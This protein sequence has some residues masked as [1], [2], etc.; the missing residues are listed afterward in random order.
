VRNII[1]SH[2]SIE[3]GYITPRQGFLPLVL[4]TPQLLLNATVSTRLVHRLTDSTTRRKYHGE[5]Y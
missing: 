5:D 3:H 1:I 2:E 4:K